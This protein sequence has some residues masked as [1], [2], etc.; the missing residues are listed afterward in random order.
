MK[1]I[2]MTAFV[3]LLGLQAQLAA[4]T[5]K[6][7]NDK[8]IKKLVVGIMDKCN[9]I[10]KQI[11]I[12]SNIKDLDTRVNPFLE[13]W[14]KK[15]YVLGSEATDQRQKIITEFLVNDQNKDKKFPDHSVFKD[16]ADLTK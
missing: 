14:T 12:V 2:I 1:K 5:K 6:Q 7:T 16:L 15:I 4:M 13:N 9:Q 3:I 11:E 8:N 10:D